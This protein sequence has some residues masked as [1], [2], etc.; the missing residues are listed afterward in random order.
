MLEESASSLK[1]FIDTLLACG[2]SIQ[3]RVSVPLCS[4]FQRIPKLVL[5]QL[6]EFIRIF[7]FILECLSFDESKQGILLTT[8]GVELA[9]VVIDVVQGSGNCLRIRVSCGATSSGHLCSEVRCFFFGSAPGRPR[10]GFLCS[11]Q[12]S[13]DMIA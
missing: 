7:V 8:F 10:R 6:P 12:V 9:K 4:C 2:I 13:D 11:P 3:I 1:D 5:A